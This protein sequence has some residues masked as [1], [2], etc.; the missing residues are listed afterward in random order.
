MK[1]QYNTD[2]GN[3]DLGSETTLSKKTPFGIV[4][5]MAKEIGARLIVKTSYISEKKP[6]RYYLK[7]YKG[8]KSDEE[9]KNI[10]EKNKSEGKYSKRES[11]LV[12][13]L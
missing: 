1:P 11:W 8:K 6:G 4:E 12:G 13:E 7:G 9:I 10:L 5:K 3:R 2:T